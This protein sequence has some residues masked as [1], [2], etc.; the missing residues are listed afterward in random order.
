[1]SLVEKF[2]NATT[3][4][5]KGLFKKQA[6]I[7]MMPGIYIVTEKNPEVAL[8]VKTSKP[9]LPITKSHDDRKDS[10]PMYEEIPV[11]KKTQGVYPIE[12][13]V[14]ENHKIYRSHLKVI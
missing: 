8:L 13:V 5:W 7:A 1:M 6:K 12:F 10:Q 9:P 2:V 4:L 14:Q 3:A 11:S